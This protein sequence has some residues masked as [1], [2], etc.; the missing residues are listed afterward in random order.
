M[1]KYY[2]AQE[3]QC[4]LEILK[5]KQFQRLAYSRH[6]CGAQKDTARYVERLKSV[7]KRHR[8]CGRK[9][10]EPTESWLQVQKP[11]VLSL[12]R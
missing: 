1:P 9:Q 4:E 2:H 10:R 12:K 5:R 3:V 11:T 6:L 8:G 7:K